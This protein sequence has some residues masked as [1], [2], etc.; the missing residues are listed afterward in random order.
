M[1]VQTSQPGKTRHLEVPLR[2]LLFLLLV[3]LLSGP[4]IAEPALDAFKET[5]QSATL[6]GEQSKLKALFDSSGP[7]EWAQSNEGVIANLIRQKAKI[8][9]F[10][11]TGPIPQH[12]GP[13]NLGGKFYRLNG[14]HLG[15]LNVVDKSNG[16]VAQ[17]PYGKVNGQYRVLGLEL[18][19]KQSETGT[20]V[21]LGLVA[22]G[23]TLNPKVN[24]KTVPF[25]AQGA[26]Q[27]LDVD[28]SPYVKK[29][30]NTLTVHWKKDPKLKNSLNRGEAHV[31]ALTQDGKRV[32]WEKSGSAD[33]A[34]E[35]K[36]SG[37]FQIQFDL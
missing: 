5:F 6:K 27:S 25:Q 14:Q 22:M 34:A 16:F 32:L 1:A 31:R 36:A 33:K 13:F 19:D 17:L 10:E 2:S 12:Q 20:T 21:R 30:R 11:L 26:S 35:S 15:T 24:G 3:Y 4:G 9:R 7:P 37:S 23:L 29:G 8:A 18:A 28:I